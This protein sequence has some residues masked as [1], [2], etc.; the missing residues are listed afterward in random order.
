MR[1]LDLEV[2]RVIRAIEL[3]ALDNVTPTLKCLIA[4]GIG[5]GG[6]LE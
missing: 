3:K 5:K 4:E 2:L 6:G 1:S